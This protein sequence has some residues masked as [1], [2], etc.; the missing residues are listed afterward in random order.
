MRIEVIGNNILI[1]SNQADAIAYLMSLGMTFD[2]IVEDPDY[3]NIGANLKSG[4][5]KQ[6][7][8]LLNDKCPLL[9]YTYNT[10][11]NANCKESAPYILINELAKNRFKFKNQ[12]IWNKYAGQKL[13]PTKTSHRKTA[14]PNDV[15]FLIVCLKN[16]TMLSKKLDLSI[17]HRG[18]SII[19][20]S[21]DQK[22][23][24]K[25]L[26][27]CVDIIN[28]LSSENSA[29]LDTNMGGANLMTAAVN[30]NRIYVGIEPHIGLFDDAV[31]RLRLL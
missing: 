31:K 25:P 1:N 22:K 28:A 17:L 21:A 6:L 19:N 10:S 20:H 3:R 14:T 5:Y 16:T 15:D 30:N 18:S 24:F 27:L 11:G 2:L 29:V 7:Y 13:I 23:Q 12:V 8:K 26:S 4:H 9:H